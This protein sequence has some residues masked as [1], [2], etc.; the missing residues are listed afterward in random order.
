M[1][2][3]FAIIGFIVTAKKALDLYFEYSDLKREKNA[4]EAA[5]QH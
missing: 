2:N 1:K 5:Q 3:L 4:R